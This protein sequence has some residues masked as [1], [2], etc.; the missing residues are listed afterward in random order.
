MATGR[1]RAEA[2]AFHRIF[3]IS[4]VSISPPGYSLFAVLT[5]VIDQLSENADEEAF[6]PD[7]F[8]HVHANPLLALGA[9]EVAQALVGS[10]PFLTEVAQVY[11]MD[12]NCCAT[13]FWAL[14]AAQKM[15]KAGSAQTVVIVA[16]DSFSSFSITERYMSACTVVGDAFVGLLLD[17]R[18]TGLQVDEI[19]LKTN[20]EFH[21][22]PY[23]SASEIQEFNRA[24]TRL[25]GEVLADLKFPAGA[26]EP[27]LPHLINRFSWDQYCAATNTKRENVW[28][29]LLPDLGHCCTTDAF[30]N[31][32]R[33][34]EADGLDSAVLV[35]VGQGGFVSGCRVK[36]PATQV[37][38]AAG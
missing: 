6:S 15:L 28:L 7:V 30:L 18:E 21:Y 25:V 1:P 26:E 27:I 13:L 17:G 22:G 2:K 16:G 35:A 38:H 31:L 9:N 4:Q 10:H 8:I 34:L 11:E 14:E 5:E 19:V 32:D 20:P 23:G 3:G 37:Q 36:K 12:Q 33:F 24:H 29:N